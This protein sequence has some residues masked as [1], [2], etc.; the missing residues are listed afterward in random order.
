MAGIRERSAPERAHS[1]SLRS[2]MAR[3]AK[4]AC[5]SAAPT[6]YAPSIRHP[7]VAALAALEGCT[8]PVLRQPGPSSFEG[9]FAATS[10]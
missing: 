8:A 5:F 9:R 2:A 10:G 4:W 1:Y 3:E 7:E 6:G